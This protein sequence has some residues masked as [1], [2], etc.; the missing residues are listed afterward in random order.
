MEELDKV[1]V[2][3]VET[4]KTVV[5]D[6][7]SRS[8]KSLRVVFSRGKESLPITLSRRDISQPYTVM[9]G[10]LEFYSHGVDPKSKIQPKFQRK[11]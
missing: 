8:D 11:R 7:L 1:I 5:A 3:C 9:I 6:V 2:H 4:D 10:E